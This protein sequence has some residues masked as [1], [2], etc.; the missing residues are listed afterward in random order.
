LATVT[1]AN[2]AA[3]AA[4]TVV[5]KPAAKKADTSTKKTPNDGTDL[6]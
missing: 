6:N 3:D 1:T 2:S 4:K 5:G